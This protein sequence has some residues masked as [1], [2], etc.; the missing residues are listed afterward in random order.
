[1]LKKYFFMVTC[2]FYQLCWK[3][4][5]IKRR[6]IQCYINLVCYYVDCAFNSNWGQHP[7][8][9]SEIQPSCLIIE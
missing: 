1:M 5:G 4:S 9:T 6:E 2:Y 7:W 8:C 3:P